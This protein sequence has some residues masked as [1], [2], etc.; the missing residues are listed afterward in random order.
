MIRIK[1]H[2]PIS[3]S[4]SHESLYENC[5]PFIYLCEEYFVSFQQIFDITF[6][7]I[8]KKWPLLNHTFVGCYHI[9]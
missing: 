3:L 4:N 2:A 6:T 5:T 8:R 9:T 7:G 1:L